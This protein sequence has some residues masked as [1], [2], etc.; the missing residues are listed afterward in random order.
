MFLFDFIN[1]NQYKY[2][3]IISNLKQYIL[4]FS[5]KLK[6]EDAETLS[7]I[8]FNYIGWRWSTTVIRDVPSIK[9]GQLWAEMSLGLNNTTRPKRN[10]QLCAK[11]WAT[12]A[13]RR[14]SELFYNTMISSYRD[15]EKIYD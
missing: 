2:I 9:L 14:A 4:T 7:L 11:G 1:Y 6:V 10:G 3:I 12:W 8:F 15:V 13:S 5:L